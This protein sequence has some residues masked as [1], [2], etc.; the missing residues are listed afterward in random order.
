MARVRVRDPLCP[1]G[2]SLAF[3]A[4]A[5][6]LSRSSAAWIPLSSN[7]ES[8]RV[9]KVTKTCT[10][11]R[12]GATEG[13]VSKPFFGMLASLFNTPVMVVELKPDGVAIYNMMLPACA[14]PRVFTSVEHAHNCLREETEEALSHG[15][16]GLC[17][18]AA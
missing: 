15:V 5:S 2:R 6:Q 16:A 10:T 14:T 17:P 3:L 7:G 11:A 8:G 18:C 4:A 1:V 12:K 13:Q 9:S